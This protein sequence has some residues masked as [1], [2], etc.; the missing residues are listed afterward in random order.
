MTVNKY[1][2]FLG[3]FSLLISLLLGFVFKGPFINF[4]LNGINISVSFS[5]VFLVI[6]VISLFILYLNTKYGL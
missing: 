4:F 5:F 2:G 6:G 1:L 3:V